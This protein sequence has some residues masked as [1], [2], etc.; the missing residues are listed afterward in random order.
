MS[1]PD[2]QR[3]RSSLR[4][5]TKPAAT[6]VSAMPRRGMA[7]YKG[8]RGRVRDYRWGT[9]RFRSSRHEASAAAWWSPS[10]IQDR[11]SSCISSGKAGSVAVRVKTS[12][13]FEIQFVLLT[14][15]ICHCRTAYRGLSQRIRSKTGSFPKRADNNLQNPMAV[16]DHL[17]LS[18]IPL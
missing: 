3:A 13:F 15:A 11:F 10:W 7:A 4:S 1:R 9:M 12:R 18:K 6:T 5:Q 8:Y 16:L 14:D 2:A 17:L